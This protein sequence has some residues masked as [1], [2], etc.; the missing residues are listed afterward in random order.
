MKAGV[1]RAIGE[2]A[3]EDVPDPELGP[4][5]VMVDV[6]LCGFCG[7]DYHMIEGRFPGGRPPRVI[8]HEVAGVIRELGAEVAG[9]EPGDRVACNLFAYCGAC[10]WCLAGQPNH[11]RRKSF[12]A[13]GFAERATYRPQQVFAIPDDLSFQ[14]AAFL[15]PAA[16]CVHAVDLAEIEPGES[17]AVVGGGA[18]GQLLVQLA[19]RAGAA[20]IILSDPDPGKRRLALEHGA[21]LAFA[22]GDPAWEAAARDCGARGGVDVAFEASGSLA[23]AAATPSLLATRG[24]LVLVAT[25][26]RGEPLPIEANLLFER[27][28]SVRGSQAADRTFPRTLAQLPLLALEPLVSAVV[29][30]ERIEEVPEMH[31]GGGSVKIMVAPQPIPDLP[32]AGE[33]R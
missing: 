22:P 2:L 29:P 3:C 5:E 30:I 21:D 18:L 33:V 19:R 13:A 12:S 14:R 23:A 31:R 8:G 24:R 16:A 6:A 9:F 27:E 20:T 11:C 32:S 17:V 7:S 1:W 26:P 28:L 25:Y 10:P 4:D 15:E